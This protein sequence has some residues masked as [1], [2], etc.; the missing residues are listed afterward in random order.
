MPDQIYIGNFP[1]GLKLD[2]T[3]FNLDNGAF[4]TLFNFYVWR[5]RAKRKRGTIYLGQLE[6]QTDLIT[7]PNPTGGADPNYITNLFTTFASTE[8][9]ANLATE[10]GANIT[11]G[12]VAIWFDKTL[13]NET[14]YIDDGLG[15]IVKDFG[16]FGFDFGNVDYV[17]GA[18]YINFGAIDIPGAGIPVVASFSYYPGLPVMGLRDFSSTP[19]TQVYPTLLAFDTRY[20]YEFNSVALPNQ[21]Y[22][23]TYYKESDVPFIWSGQNYQQ[24]WV[25]NYSGAAWATNN[26]PGFHFVQAAYVSGSGT[27]DITFVFTKNAVPFEDLVVDDVIWFNEWSGGSTINTITG[28]VVTIVDA[29]TGT[30]IVRFSSAQTVAGT[31]IAQFLTNS[32]T[33]EDGI[34]WYDGDPTSGTGLPTGTG[35]GWVNF[36]PPLTASTVSINNLPPRLYYLVGALAIVEFKDRLLFFS[37]YVQASTGVAIQLADTV[38]WSWNGTPYYTVSSITVT[39]GVSTYTPSLVPTN[40]TADPTAYYVDQTGKGGWL[41]AG[42]AQPIAT[43]NSNEDVLLVGFSGNGRKTRFVYT[44]N[45]LQPFLFFSI[46]S[47]LPSGSTFS[48]V[49]LDRGVIDVGQYGIAMTDQQSSQ[50][51]D[52]DIPDSVFQIQGLNHGIER[53]SG[54][55]DFFRE[56]IYFSYPVNTSRW[57]FPTQ[58]FLFNYRDNTW[59]IFYENFTAH[60]TYRERTKRSWQTLPFKTWNSWREPWNAGSSS[61][62]FPEIVG[63]TPEGYVLIKGQG[64]YEAASG[65]ILNI[66]NFGGLTQIKSVNHC[67][68]STTIGVGDYLLVDGATGIPP[69]ATITAIVNSVPTIVNAVNTFT[70]GQFVTIDGVVGMTELNGNTYEI[71]T[72]SPTVFV[73]DV[74]S[75]DFNSYISG[76]TA[77]IPFNG[78]IGKVQSIINADNFV[79]DLRYPFVDVTTTITGATATNP[80]VLTS[81][82]SYSIGDQIS[83]SGVVGMTQLNGNTYSITAVSGTTITIGVDGSAFTPYASGG[84]T[85]LIQYHGGGRFNRLSLPLL[86][87]KQFNFYWETGRKVRLCAQKYLLDTTPNSQVTVNI[88][89]S[90]DQDNAWNGPTMDPSPNG[91]IYSQLMYTCPEST[92]IGLTPS[93]VNLQMPIAVNQAQIWHRFNTS[94]IG[95]SVQIGITL[96]DTQMRNITYA[97]AE[98]ALHALQLNI[99][100]G[101]LL[102]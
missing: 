13:G 54:I 58:T 27:T 10:P 34:K 55:R 4:P 46:N 52:L 96:D 16:V 19:S 51:V 36:A 3:A 87:T 66:I 40:Q 91:I 68:S 94:L 41:S 63:G 88:Y 78:N 38:I 32:I 67:V 92:N 76:G 35:L 86:Q 18:V 12:S 81:V 6:R 23:V 62:F 85:F 44:G 20:S 79:I 59:G 5:G 69:T 7:Q 14:K 75:S 57:T 53:V 74:N 48:A 2:R 15:N 33:G 22:N 99:D 24:F 101:P 95:D 11:P 17:T 50:R 30:Y 72:A 26:K 89:L 39:A 83:I 43:V 90:Q 65:T 102:A 82:N 45:D 93:N 60:G 77:S 84:T 25:T 80:V 56:W 37:P 1:K 49:S 71:L 70:A 97:T 28:I 61:P 64:T 42:I 9:G 21:F 98:I 100:K 47:E 73:I 29:T 31:G 8:A